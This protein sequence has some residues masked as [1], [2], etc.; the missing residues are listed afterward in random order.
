MR[1]GFCDTGSRV[2]GIR[3]VDQVDQAV[4][5]ASSPVRLIPSPNHSS[6]EDHLQTPASSVNHKLVYPHSQPATPTL[7][8]TSPGGHFDRMSTTIEPLPWIDAILQ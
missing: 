2:E 6:G 3:G 4:L 5:G 7:K 1:L 8:S